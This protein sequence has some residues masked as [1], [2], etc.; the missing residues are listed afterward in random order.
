MLRPSLL[1]A[2]ALA[3]TVA[4]SGEERHRPRGA[5]APDPSAPEPPALEVEVLPASRSVRFTTE[6][7]VEIV[8]TLQ[9]AAHADAPAVVL[10]HQLGSDRSEWAP[11]LERLHSQPSLTT[12]AIDMRGHGESTQSA[13]GALDWH[14]FDTDAWARARL[15]VRAALAFLR[16]DDSG[17]RPERF[18]AVG[19]SIGS[20]A[21]IAAAAEEPA[22]TTLVTLS[23][24]RAYHGFDA[25]TPAI[26][27]GDRAILAI[28]AAEEADSVD[29]AEAYG[30]IGHTPAVV[31]PG[32]A[33][34]VA[35]FAL[36]PSTV[37]RTEG[38]LREH[39]GAPRPG[40]SVPVVQP[41]APPSDA[42]QPD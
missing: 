10:L 30:R 7:G 37:D 8:G 22:L 15:D 5:A 29:T 36:D 24:G 16:S 12:L 1:L 41:E 9:P 14:A 40:L 13:S 25:I 21:V 20:S 17:V 27:L 42:L 38:F 11:L 18:A 31:V 35:L 33:H 4:C 34:G 28:V 6:D 19:S 23:P 26:G 39:L 2:L 32:N 3:L